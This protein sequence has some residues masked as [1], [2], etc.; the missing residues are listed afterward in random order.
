MLM[1]A[2]KAVRKNRFSL[3][4]AA[5][6]YGIRKS[7]INNHVFKRVNKV[8][9]GLP[10]YLGEE[11][12]QRLYR[13]LIKMACIGYGQSKNDLFDHIQAI[14]K[15]LKWEMKFVDGHPGEQWYQLI[16]QCFLHLKLNQAQLLSHQHASIS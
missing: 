12:E 9:P 8:Q 13:W 2:V 11:L 6:L 16:L 14:I 4:R 1:K 3:C 7:M 5:D 10:P 15:W